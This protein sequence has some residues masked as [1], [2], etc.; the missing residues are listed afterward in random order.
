VNLAVP[1]LARQRPSPPATLV[2][3]H[4]ETRRERLLDMETRLRRYRTACFAI[5][6]AV[7]E[8]TVVDT[9]DLIAPADAALYAAGGRDS[10][11]V[12]S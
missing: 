6:V 3:I 4:Q 11:F 5:G 10:V 9:D 1:A 8:P 2:S 7:S 12:D